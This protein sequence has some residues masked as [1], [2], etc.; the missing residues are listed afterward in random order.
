MVWVC[1]CPTR[2]N[3]TFSL[4]F[5]VSSKYTAAQIADIVQ[6]GANVV[7][8]R[9]LSNYHVGVVFT[10]GFNPDIDNSPVHD[11]LISKGFY[12]LVI[13]KGTESTIHVY[14]ATDTPRGEFFTMSVGPRKPR[15]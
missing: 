1:R 15:R 11:F 7:G 8:A 14:S 6:V 5:V 9:S 13:W 10:R 3:N 2:S 12:P 4:F